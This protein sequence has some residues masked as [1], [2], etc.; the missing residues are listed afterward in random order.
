MRT[1]RDIHQRDGNDEPDKF[2][3][4]GYGDHWPP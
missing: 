1:G 2:H 3:V 4:L